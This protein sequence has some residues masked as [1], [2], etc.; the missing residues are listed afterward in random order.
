MKKL[1]SHA[2]ADY[3][4]RQGVEYVFGLCGHT[5]IGMLDALQKS[6]LKFISVRHEQIAAHAADGYART[7][8]K[9]G[10]VL[11]H[12]GP[13]LTN[14]T[15]GVA[16]AALDNIPMVVIAGDIPSYYYGKHPH[17]EFNLHA[18]ASQY[19]IYKPFVK[20]AWRIERPEAFPEILDKAF[21]MAVSGRP[22][23]VLISVPMDMFSREIDMIH[24][25]RTYHHRMNIAK[26]SLD[27]E[28]GEKIIDM[29][30]AAKNPVIHYGGGILL[31]KASQELTD[32][33]D[34]LDIPATRTLMG[35]GG[36]SDTHPLAVGMTGF[37]GTEY[38]N[39]TTKNAD[40]ILGLGT[41]FAEA[42]SSSWYGGV[43]F[44]IPP[45][46]LIHIDID[47]TEI[48]RNFPVEIGAVADLKAA[49]KDL[50]AVA[51]KKK[52]EGVQRPELRKEIKAYKEA[53]KKSNQEVEASSQ[54]PMTPQRILQDVRETLPED[55]IILT[56]V[57]W[58][59]NGM[60]QQFPITVPGT[61]LHPGGLATMGFG[62][63][64]VLG[65][66]LGAPHKKVITMV[67]DGGFGTNPS[68]MATAVEQG[69]PVV[70]VV[71]NNGAFGTIAGLE[72]GHYHHT[73]GTV[74]QKPDGTRY[75]PEWAEVAKAYG[76][77]AKK[78]TS[79]KEFKEVFKEALDANEPY[80]IDVPMENIPVP[81]DGIW[82]INDIYTPKEN[83]V[84]G[85]LMYGEPAKSKHVTTK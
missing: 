54:F 59:K 19:E 81:T 55:G 63:S 77:K 26:P 62:P 40:V 12:L 48:G 10:V 38:V 49:L 30:L 65:A 35:Q 18:D 50:L 11:L 22:G 34:F 84:E 8:G 47:P 58:N 21:T 73:F 36:L 14:A 6:K 39:N 27:Q 70:W 79:A 56:D 72:A 13:G 82:N 25:E 9:P 37:W 17:Q 76:I 2:L 4:E 57:G 44:N 75:N 20:R 78:I 67:G 32:F 45:T 42:D 83:V 53:F 29:L 46:K 16:N 68:V 24:F 74:F 61:I 80:L 85:K 64:A 43:T 5:V 1:V 3:L 69:I 71:M 23:P 33:V 7:S 51:K 60:G 66:K 52:P 15:T 31:A 41:T 28:T